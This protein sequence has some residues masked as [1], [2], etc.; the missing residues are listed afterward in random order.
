M[1]DLERVVEAEDVDFLRTAIRKHVTLTGSRYAEAL[2]SEWA[3]L[4]HRVVKVMPREY[5]QALAATAAAGRA[6]LAEQTVHG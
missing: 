2:L 1:V 3:A 4:Q 6:E 5:K